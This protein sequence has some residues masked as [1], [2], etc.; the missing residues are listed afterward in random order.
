MTAAPR[1]LTRQNECRRATN[2]K[3]LNMDHSQESTAID[4]TLVC[5]PWTDSLIDRIGYDP[6]STYVETFWLPIL[7]PSVTWL[8]RRL[9]T[10]VS[11]QDRVIIDA[12]EL[13]VMIGVNAKTLGKTID[14]LCTFN[15]ARRNDTVLEVRRKLP[16][17]S[18]KY[19]GQLPPLLRMRHQSEVA[20]SSHLVAS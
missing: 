2:R 19:V 11:L 9:G 4:G 13:A 10:W 17:L 18:H 12:D 15:A 20:R 6:T 7:G 1:H 14:R 8:Y 5:A 3:Q 16:R